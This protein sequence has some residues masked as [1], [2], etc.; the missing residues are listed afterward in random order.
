MCISIFN[1]SFYYLDGNSAKLG[2]NIVTPPV[3]FLLTFQT[4][5]FLFNEEAM[6]FSKPTKPFLTSSH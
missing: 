3:E 6:S 5:K 4:I 2:F 1:F